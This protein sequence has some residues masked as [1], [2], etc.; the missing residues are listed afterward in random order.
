MKGFCDILNGIETDFIFNRLHRSYLMPPL[1]K[2][3]LTAVGESTIEVIPILEHDHES[4]ANFFSWNF[5]TTNG[6]ES[7][8]LYIGSVSVPRD[9]KFSAISGLGIITIYTTLVWTFYNLIKR[10]E[11]T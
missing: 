2:T 6:S 4:G 1:D 3:E 7:V 5:L 10:F 11:N 9:N 8:R